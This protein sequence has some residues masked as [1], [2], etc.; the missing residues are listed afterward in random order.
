MLEVVVVVVVVVAFG[1]EDCAYHDA[2]YLQTTQR[3]P[4]VLARPRIFGSL[5]YPM[6]APLLPTTL[7]SSSCFA[8]YW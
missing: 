1:V 3:L 7:N 8:L 6:I 5:G 2:D 4:R